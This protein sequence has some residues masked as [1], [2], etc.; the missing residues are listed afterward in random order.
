MRNILIV[1]LFIGCSPIK[2]IEKNPKLYQEIKEMVIANG[3]CVN[4]TTIITKT[5]TTLVIDTL[6]EQYFDTA[7]INDTIV[8]WDKKIYNF[9][10]TK[11]IRDTII[12]YVSNTEE[13]GIW[14][15]KENKLKSEISSEK[16]KNQLAIKIII[17][18]GLFL[19]LLFYMLIKRR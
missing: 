5:D 19:L 12:K 6:I 18:F 9:K 10:E 1:L 7:I 15:K 13:R 16:S 3:D 2:Q 4:D 17:G 14:L 8:I 11:T